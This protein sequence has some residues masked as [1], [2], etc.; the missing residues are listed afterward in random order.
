MLNVCTAQPTGDK[1]EDSAGAAGKNASSAVVNGGLTDSECM[2]TTGALAGGDDRVRTAGVDDNVGTTGLAGSDDI[3]TA[4]RQQQQLNG[5]LNKS[6]ILL[7]S[8][9][10]INLTSSV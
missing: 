4:G 7:R 1:D 5:L 9:L 6:I 8:V 2:G 3:G 10:Y